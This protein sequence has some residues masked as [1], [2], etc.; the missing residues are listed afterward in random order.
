MQL[1]K[2]LF[3]TLFILS[4]SFLFSCEKEEEAQTVEEKIIGT[5]Q[6]QSV[7]CAWNPHE[8]NNEDFQG[9]FISFLDDNTLIVFEN[10]QEVQNTTWSL[11]K[12]NSDLRFILESDVE[13][14]KGALTIEGGEMILDARES[15]GC[16]HVFY[17]Q[18]ECEVY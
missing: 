6:W 11:D 13:Q 2:A 15:D 4:L 5:W 14:L 1:N 12:S 10:D 18:Y 17:Q 3:F 16:K 8:A 7:T 9:L